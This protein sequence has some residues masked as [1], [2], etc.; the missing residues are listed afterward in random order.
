MNRENIF[1]TDS[2][3]I[4]QKHIPTS[5]NDKMATGGNILLAPNG[6]PSGLY[7][8]EIYNLVRTPEFKAWF[9]DWEEAYRTKD[10]E[11]VSKIIDENGE[12]LICVHNTPNEFYEFDEEET[13]G[14][15]SD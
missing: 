14:E 12:P 2:G 8:T 6:E 11:G 7:F 9:G 1:F 13:A 3:Q 5:E 10:Y 4:G 15:G